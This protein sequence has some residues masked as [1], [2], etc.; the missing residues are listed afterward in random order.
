MCLTYTRGSGKTS[1]VHP[2]WLP[3]RWRG[4]LQ[5]FRR[6]FTIVEQEWKR[7]DSDF[8]MQTERICTLVL[9]WTSSK[10][11]K[12]TSA[13]QQIICTHMWYA[14]NHL[15]ITVQYYYLLILLSVSK[16][17]PKWFLHNEISYNS[18]WLDDHLW[19]AMMLTNQVAILQDYKLLEYINKMKSNKSSWFNYM[20]AHP[21]LQ[22]YIN[23][24]Q[25]HAIIFSNG[26][27]W[28]ISCIRVS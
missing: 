23:F 6:H 27:T 7:N 10:S 2:P 8:D 21:K 14:L 9:H 28:C 5:T 1:H 16:M 11:M 15:V 25:V 20:T 26:I 12:H 18:M 4:A 22:R 17:R 13:Y 3:R 24:H 19:Y